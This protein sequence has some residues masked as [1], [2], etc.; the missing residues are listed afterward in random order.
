M[1]RYEA[2]FRDLKSAGRGAFVPFVVLGD[3]DPRTSLRILE[4]LAAGG[5][6]ALEL[7]IPFSDP[8]ADGPVI[9]EA[10]IR[11]LE[12]SVTCRRA[13][14]IIH[15]FR[16][17]HPGLPL[18]LLVYANLVYNGGGGGEEDA[19]DP[20]T[21]KAAAFY[22]GA[23]EAGADSVLIADLPSLEAAPFSRLAL[24][25]GVAPVQI[26][27]PNTPPDRLEQIAGNCR[28][29]TYVVSRSGVTGTERESGA[30]L[31][32]LFARLEKAGAPPPLVGFGVSRPEHVTRII[33]AGAAGAICGSAIVQRISRGLDDRKGMLKNLE[34][35]VREMREAALRPQEEAEE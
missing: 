6:D 10:D 14:E 2:L 15:A 33:R 22:R 9:Q 8:V 28:G 13:F 26:V 29:Y 3:P 19:V 21:G 1:D 27:A 18:G 12:A 34:L 17:G 16:D 5:A 20:L 7:G 31:E 23:S 24:Q 25:A 30:G 32:G 4:A 35:F 11:A